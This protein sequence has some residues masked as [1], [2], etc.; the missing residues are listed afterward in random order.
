MFIGNYLQLLT[1]I[2]YQMPYFGD[3]S[4]ISARISMRSTTVFDA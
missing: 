3:I 1:S 4:I 2:V